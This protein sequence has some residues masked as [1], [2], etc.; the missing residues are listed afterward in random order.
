MALLVIH[1][2]LGIRLPLSRRRNPLPLA[3]S[4]LGL[5]LPVGRQ[6]RCPLLVP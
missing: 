1:S 3:V 5:P 4:V 6:N 2:G